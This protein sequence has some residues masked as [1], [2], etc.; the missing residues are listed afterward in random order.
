MSS[1]TKLTIKAYSDPQLSSEAGSY[2]ARVNPEK[3]RLHYEV[4]YNKQPA[5]GSESVPAL[6][7]HAPA[8]ELSFELLFDATGAIPNSATDL[9]AEIKSF[10]HLVY[11][12]QGN[13]HQPYYLKL[14][15][16]SLVFGARLKQLE[17]SYTLFRPDGS[18][19][20]AAASVT[21][22]SFI[23]PKTMAAQENKSSPDMTHGITVTEGDTLPL[24]CYRIYGDASLYPQ[25]ARANG[26]THFQKL[27]AGTRLV[28]PPLSK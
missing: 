15:W 1:P 25:V 21:F 17:L 18:P 7:D 16:G 20:R 28:F 6:F 10:L 26:L 19:L 12:Y 5:A 8:Q 14:F 22:V 9:S 3:Y 24:L 11:D 4:V 27:T 2:T 13:I 23:D